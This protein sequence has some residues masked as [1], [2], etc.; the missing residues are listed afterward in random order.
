MIRQMT[1]RLQ[2][3][4]QTFFDQVKKK[5]G[6]TSD[7][8]TFGFIVTQYES[9]SQQSGKLIFTEPTNDQT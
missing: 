5:L 2:E 3:D 8:Q 9:A 7:S 4:K 1:I 6:L